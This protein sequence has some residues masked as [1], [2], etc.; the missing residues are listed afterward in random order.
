ML[1]CG[2]VTWNRDGHH[3]LLPG[4]KAMQLSAPKLNESSN[5]K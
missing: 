5:T 4:G 3:R 2:K 1:E